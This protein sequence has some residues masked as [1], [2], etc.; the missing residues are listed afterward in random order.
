VRSESSSVSSLGCHANRA[1][2]GV[3][4]GR[5]HRRG[6]RGGGPAGCGDG[7]D[8]G[9]ATTKEFAQIEALSAASCG[10][11]E[12]GGEGEPTALIA[13]DLPLQGDSEERSAQ[14]NEATRLALEQREWRA[15]SSRVAFQAC[16]D[17]LAETDE[18][19]EARCRENARAYADNPDVIGVIGTYN[20]G[21]AAE[22]T[23]ILNEAPDGGVAMISPGNTL[24]CLTEPSPTCEIQLKDLYPSGK[25]NYA[26]VVPHDAFEGAGLASFAQDQGVR[27]PYILRAAEDPFGLEQAKA[28]RGAMQALG[29][30]PAGFGTWDP[31]AS[32][33]RD[34]MGNVK[35]AGA[36]ALV[37]ASFLFEKGPL[38]VKDKV[39]V[40]GPNDGRVKLFATDGLAEQ[41][42]IASTGPPAAGMFVTVPG[43]DP[44]TLKGRGQ[45]F[46]AELEARQ[47]GD[48][49]VELYA[50][51]AAQATE[52]LLDAIAPSPKRA[53][54]IEAL[55]QT[56]IRDGIIGDFT[57]TPSGD[58]STGAVSVSVADD[59]GT[60]A[61]TEVVFPP[62]D[63]VAAA[64]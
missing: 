52:V 50:P 32:D 36:D 6:D 9:E 24:I 56:R 60:F 21:C 62:P 3:H 27:R 15:G 28:V 20:S 59:S 43:Q 22:I 10:E 35:A 54:V 16:D 26:R 53:D 45:Q 7:D 42:T 55:F 11:V 63:V 14:M 58:P 33:Y 38:M 19:D 5:N 57:L 46:V 31:E 30:Q 39:E 29:M 13:S 23:P 4:G 37:L 1:A 2:Q 18:W 47:E 44:Q 61:H 12:Y 17:A 48:E 64:G 49:P 34:L 40:L 41:D 51:Y 25:R 8:G